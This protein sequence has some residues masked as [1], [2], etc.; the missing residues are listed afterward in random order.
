MS[1]R[2][3]IEL[4][5]LIVLVT[6]TLAWLV[7]TVAVAESTHWHVLAIVPLT[8]LFGALQYPLLTKYAAPETTEAGE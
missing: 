7:A 6:A 8:F 2:K 3:S 1:V 5:D 4:G